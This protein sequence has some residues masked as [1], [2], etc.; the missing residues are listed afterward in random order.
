[1]PDLTMI[2]N[3]LLLFRM[4]IHRCPLIHLW[5]SWMDFIP[6]PQ[7]WKGHDFFLTCL[8]PVKHD[9]AT[10]VI[11]RPNF[12]NNSQLKKKKIPFSPVT[13]STQH[14][15]LQC[16]AVCISWHSRIILSQ[17]LLLRKR[18]KKKVS[19]ELYLNPGWIY[20]QGSWP[21]SWPAKE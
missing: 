19:S 12:F 5:G 11:L 15:Q 10:C 16:P 4:D 17:D 8:F 14:F 20:K 18:L 13:L 2:A 21:V 9:L 3:I 6:V 1:M 7:L